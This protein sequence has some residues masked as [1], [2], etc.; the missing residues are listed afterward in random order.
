MRTVA[1]GISRRD[2]SVS[3]SLEVYT[4]P[5]TEK[6][7]KNR[8][9][10][11]GRRREGGGRIVDFHEL[12]ACLRIEVGDFCFTALSRLSLGGWQAFLDLRARSLQGGG[13]VR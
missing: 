3:A 5:A 9:L 12:G 4:L 8:Q 6:V 1:F 2:I 11:F 7:E 10:K 13:G